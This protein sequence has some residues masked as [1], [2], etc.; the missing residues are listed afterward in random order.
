MKTGALSIELVL[1]SFDIQAHLDESIKQCKQLGVTAPNINSGR[2]YLES[3]DKRIQHE[4]QMQCIPQI[5]TIMKDHIQRE[6]Y[7]V[8]LPSYYHRRGLSGG[9]IDDYNLQTEFYKD[10]SNYIVKITLSVEF[11]SPY[12][13]DKHN[14]DDGLGRMLNDYGIYPLG[15]SDEDDAPYWAQPRPFWDNAVDEI[16]NLI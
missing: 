8:Y 5:Q 4:L 1:G 14:T 13:S 9:M 2:I 6:V 7:D 3:L 10:G 15:Y 16:L 11:N 12:S